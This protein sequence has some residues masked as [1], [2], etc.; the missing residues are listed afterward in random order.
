MYTIY[1]DYD[2]RVIPP[3]V[4]EVAQSVVAKYNA[5]ELVTKRQLVNGEIR[6][7]LTLRL[8]KY[9]IIIDDV[10]ITQLAL[11]EVRF[12]VVEPCPIRM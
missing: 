5:T 9:K 1:L 7:I 4:K 8:A 11:P 6:D 3:L 12:S 2:E 10:V